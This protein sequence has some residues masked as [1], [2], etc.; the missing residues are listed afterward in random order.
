[1]N[2]HVSCFLPCRAGSERVPKKN[3]KPFVGIAHGLVELKISQLL[4]CGVI[5]EVVLSTNDEQILDYA[6]NLGDSRLRLHHRDNTLSSSKTSTDELVA[7]AL[8]L[9]PE[10]HILWTHVTSPFINAAVYQSIVGSYF[11]ALEQGYDSLMTTTE[12]HS[13]L[14]R[15]GKPLNYDRAVEKWP[16][17]QTLKAI[18]EV[19]SGAF[20]ASSKIYKE[21]NDRIGSK[22][23]LYSM[24][25]LIGHDIDWPEDFLIAEA[26]FEKGLVFL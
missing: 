2:R 18:H 19:N 21:F 13:F 9:I 14:W 12:L 24:G 7:H 16:R 17:T 20:L 10:G 5:D 6:S 22:T 25:K 8:A 11:N 15:E 3:I 26:L 23:Y 1:M 4:S